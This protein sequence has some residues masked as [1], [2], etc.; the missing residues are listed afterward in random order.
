MVAL[1]L[2]FLHGCG[3]DDFDDTVLHGNG[4]DDFDGSIFTW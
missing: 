2:V 3:N 4:N 1:M